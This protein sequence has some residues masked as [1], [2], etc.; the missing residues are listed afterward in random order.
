MSGFTLSGVKASI[1][2][3]IIGDIPAGDF[4]IGKNFLVKNITEDIIQVS[5]LPAGNADYITTKLYPGW[6]PEIIKG[7]KGVEANKLQY[8]Y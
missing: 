3:A 4:A 6:N 2:V 5:V 1:Q 8:G 7:L